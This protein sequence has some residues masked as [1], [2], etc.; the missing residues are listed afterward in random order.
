[1]ATGDVS[2]LSCLNRSQ[3]E[4]FIEVLTGDEKTPVFW[5]TLPDHPSAAN[6]APQQFVGTLNECFARLQEASR[7]GQGVFL[8]VNDPSGPGARRG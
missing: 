7:Q 1:M 5:T 8:A 6:T 3:A 2:H 4:S